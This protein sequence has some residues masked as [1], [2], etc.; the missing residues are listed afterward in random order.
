MSEPRVAPMKWPGFQPT[1]HEP[2]CE[3]DAK[4]HVALLHYEEYRCDEHKPTADR[5]KQ[6]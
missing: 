2:G 3:N 4:W 5:G 1:C 6:T